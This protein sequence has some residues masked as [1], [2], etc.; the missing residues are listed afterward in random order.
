MERNSKQYERQVARLKQLEHERAIIQAE[1]WGKKRRG[2]RTRNETQDDIFG[3][4]IN[5]D[6]NTSP[7]VRVERPQVPTR[8]KVRPTRNRKNQEKMN[9]FSAKLVTD[10]ESC[11]SD[12][13]SNYSLERS[14]KLITKQTKI[15]QFARGGSSGRYSHNS[16]IYN[17]MSSNGTSSCQSETEYD[18]QTGANSEWYLHDKTS[19]DISFSDGIDRSIV[20]RN[21]QPHELDGNIYALYD[22]MRVIVKRLIEVE[23]ANKKLE[24]QLE[25]LTSINEVGCDY[26][27]SNFDN[28]CCNLTQ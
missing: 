1:L 16:T 19:P 27:Y 24:R 20:N 9:N 3:E 2:Q 25:V 6:K 12:S 22:K 4:N 21:L 5:V 17:E 14:R 26:I 15:K 18:T 13:Y 7:V 11:S 8:T 23:N 10:E 28:S